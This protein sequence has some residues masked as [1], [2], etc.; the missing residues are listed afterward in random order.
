MS[1]PFG[2]QQWM[3]SDG[4]YTHEIGNSARLDNNSYY[5]KS[6]ASGGNRKTWT[7]SAWVKRSDITNTNNYPYLFSVMTTSNTACYM[8]FELDKI[9]IYEEANGTDQYELI[10]TQEFRDP[11]AWYHLVLSFDTTQSTS[12]NRIKLYVNGEQVT[13]FGTSDYPNQNTDYLFNINSNHYIGQRGNGQSYY[14]GYITEINFING[15]A[16][17]ASYFGETKANT[18]IPKKYTGSYGTNGFYLDFATRATD[19]IDASP[20]GNNW[21]SVNVVATDSMLDSPTNNFATLNPLAHNG[22]TT[23]ALTTSEGNLKTEHSHAGNWQSMQGTIPVSSGKWYYEVQIVARPTNNT[24]NYNIGFYD[25]SKY[26][27]GYYGL[28]GNLTYGSE[29]TGKVFVD[30]AKTSYG[31]V[32]GSDGDIYMFALDLDNNKFW[33]GLNGTWMA[34]GNPSTGANPSASN[35]ATE[36]GVARTYVS[37]QSDYTYG[38]P[39]GIFI[40]NYG[41]DSSFAGTKTAQGNIDANSIGDF[42]YS[43]PTGFLALCTANLPDPTA[44]INP[45]VNNSPQDYFNTVLY[46]GNGSNTRTI[47]GVGFDP[48]LVWQKSRSTAINHNL[49]DRLRGAGNNLSSDGAFA[50]YG[51]GTNGA[52]NNV[53]TDGASILAGS[54]S[55]NNVNQSGQT[56]VLWNWKAGGSG[57]SNSDGTT[58]SVVSA[59][60]DAGFS[61]VTYTGT[62]SAGMTIGHGLSSAPELIIVKNRA[63]GSENWTVYSSSLGNTKKLELNLTGASATTGNWNNTTPSSSVFTLGNV[64]ATNTSGES[65]VAY[66]FHSV[67]GFS[68]FGTYT[69]NGSADGTFVY[70]GFRPAFVM[71]KNVGAS[72]NWYMVDTARDPHNESYHLLRSDL[73]NAEASGSV[74]G[75]DILSNGFKLKVAGGGWINGSG[76]TFLYM[77]FAEMPFKYANAK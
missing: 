31:T 26:N 8:R 57:V 56:Y 76:N 72:E 46:T 35:F 36:N 12:S 3:Y 49:I 70:T 44:A 65:C 71:W 64:D 14:N 18:W 58:A 62:G 42:Y 4:F 59:N 9:K 40:H 77:A 10:T 33:A 38:S 13:A 17:D 7:W 1:G 11:S 48:D 29:V 24:Q 22:T 69:G 34:S 67:E 68:K 32:A 30:T 21:G 43:V 16:L 54:S 28:S 25:V 45:A 74:D 73:S 53:E 20:N 39:P 19:P 6:F 37:H 15:Q 63:D 66:C 61:I 50:E 51:A 75:L 47:T 23:T 55:A 60:T 5:V 2:S 27:A 41:Q 52:M